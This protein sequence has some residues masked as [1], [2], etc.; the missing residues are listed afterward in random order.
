MSAAP[1]HDDD[2]R[3]FDGGGAAHRRLHDLTLGEL[4]A[5]IDLRVLRALSKHEDRMRT[6]M[7]RRFDGMCELIKSG[8]P[9]G[10]PAAHRRAHE[11]W[12]R[13]SLSRREFWSWV[14]RQVVIVVALALLGF[15]GLAAWQHLLTLAKRDMPVIAQ[16]RADER[17]RNEEP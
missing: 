12:I 10:D 9:E 17:G 8:F 14:A 4:H 16:P 15:L 3:D 7:D 1:D 11:S 2:D 13:G 6:H 5:H